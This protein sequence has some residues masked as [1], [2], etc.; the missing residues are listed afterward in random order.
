MVDIQA[1]AG[2]VV[3]A[4]GQPG[5]SQASLMM[6][7]RYD[8]LAMAHTQAEGWSQVSYE[9]FDDEPHR[10][11]FDWGGLIGNVLAGIAIAAC[12]G[13]AV[14]ASMLFF[15]AVIAAVAGTA[16]ASSAVTAAYVI[17]GSL[18]LRGQRRPLARD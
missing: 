10:G 7:S 17:G 1:P 4:Q 2:E 8:L 14:A 11:K 9:P 12:V 5:G 18:L 6:S 15:P 16:V 3:M 13:A